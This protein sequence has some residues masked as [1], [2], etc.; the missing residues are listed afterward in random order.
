M[1]E[2]EGGLVCRGQ[3]APVSPHRLEQ[4]E[5]AHDVGLYE[6]FRAVDGAVHVAFGGKVQHRAGA[7]FGQQAVHQRAVAQVA[8]HEGV[9]LIPLQAGQVFQVAGVG[10][11]VEVD[12][13]L[14]GLGQPVEYEIAA[15]EAGSASHENHCE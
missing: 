9:A 15:D 11:L 10:E 5:S 1:Q 12:H 14:I 2:A 8:V 7:V 6:I 4:A 3:A 13:R